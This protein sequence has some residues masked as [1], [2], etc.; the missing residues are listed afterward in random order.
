[1]CVTQEVAFSKPNYTWFNDTKQI[2]IKQA[3]ICCVKP[4]QLTCDSLTLRKADSNESS[5]NRLE[6]L[7]II[8]M[9]WSVMLLLFSTYSQSFEKICTWQILGLNALKTCVE[10]FPSIPVDPS[11]TLPA[12]REKSEYLWLVRMFCSDIYLLLMTAMT[13]KKSPD[14]LG[15]SFWKRFCCCLPP[16]W[17][18][19][20]AF[21]KVTCSGTV[22]SNGHFCEVIVS[23]FFLA[24]LVSLPL[25]R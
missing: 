18:Y 5:Q 14:I 17:N 10:N 20:N 25:L 9:L 1:M 22:R 2:S 16:K 13:F 3:Y 7:Q 23:T 15:R 21:I 19:D 4:K 11:T 8:K 24:R 12:K 6:W